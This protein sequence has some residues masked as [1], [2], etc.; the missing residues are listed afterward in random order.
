MDQRVSFRIADYEWPA[1][2]G[3]KPF[4]HQKVTT[5]FLIKNK[6]A[7]VLND[8]GTGKT[9]SAIWAADILMCAEKI[10][11]VL[12]VCPLSTMKSVWL[13][14]LFLNCP[15]RIAAIA[16]GPKEKRIQIVRNAA[17]EFVIINHDGV[18]ILEDELIR[19]QFD[20]CVID[21]LTA[22]KSNSDRSKA[23]RRVA[24]S[25]RAV[26]GMTGDLTPNSPC[27]AF[28]PCHIVNPKNEWL[29]KYYGQFRD[30]CMVQV[31]EYT[32]IAKPEAPQIVAMCAQPAVRFTRDQCLDLP[33]TTY[34]TLEIDLTPEQTAYYNTMAQS[35][36]VES[37]SGSITAQNAA[38]KL[39]KLL[40]ISAGAVKND[41]GDV[42]EIG[43]KDRLD[44]LNRVFEETP[45]KKLVV[46]ATYRASIEMI[47]RD[48]TKR[49]H[50]VA[51][52]HGGVPQNVRAQFI[53]RFQK[54]DLQ[55][56]VL[57]PQSSAHGITLTAASTIVWFSLLPSNELFQQGN[58]R[59]I[60]AGQ[61]RKTLIIMFVST[62]AEKHIARILRNRMNMSEEILKLF[63]DRDL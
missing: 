35:A 48:M 17:Y 53:D 60:R 40:Q 57:Q 44:E 9:L 34:Q 23:M 16:H 41:V 27:E 20:V 33:D 2:M 29:P 56:L 7:F 54:G 61:H 11:R 62:K 5:L 15:H 28:Y 3:R 39:N 55:I 24:K 30:A 4:A 52:I 43:C 19:Q 25:C 32:W 22:F 46:F 14:E 36:L 45:Q 12:V 59:I 50:I 31:N 6:G 10:R 13:N 38:I 49:G 58:A 1:F 47:V 37:E 21:E 63:V 26:W 18:K 51:C 8:M 42:V